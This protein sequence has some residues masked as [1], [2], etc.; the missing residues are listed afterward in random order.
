MVAA[1]TALAR[2]LERRFP[3]DGFLARATIK[4]SALTAAP[5]AF[6]T[7][8]LTAAA[9]IGPGDCPPG[10]A[11]T[12][13]W[14]AFCCELSGGNNRV[15]PSY[16][17]PAGWWR[18][19]GLSSSQFCADGGNK[20]TRFIVD[21]GKKPTDSCPDGCKCVGQDCNK[22][23]TCCNPQTYFQCNTG[24]SHTGNI[25]CRLVTCV[26]PSQIGCL[27]CNNNLE[28]DDVT[29]SHEKPCFT[30]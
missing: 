21:C 29:C 12:D 15:C 17:F 11:C 30:T 6:V 13:G 26:N 16:A 27:N 9:V 24:T 2:G 10:S 23:R 22:R 18:C 1:V 19:Q 4:A 14:T 5:V 8:P 28:V 20:N 7:K 3:H 25:V